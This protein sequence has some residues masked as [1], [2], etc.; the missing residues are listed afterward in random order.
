MWMQIAKGFFVFFMKKVLVKADFIQYCFVVIKECRHGNIFSMI[1]R[2]I[3]PRKIKKWNKVGLVPT[4][5]SR[6]LFVGPV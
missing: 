1:K 4:S 2:G 5:F 6:L 3:R